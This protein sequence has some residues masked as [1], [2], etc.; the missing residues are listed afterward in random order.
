[1]DM[2]IFTRTKLLIGSAALEKLKNSHVV[3]CGCGG[4]GSYSLEALARAGV[5]QIT[6]IDSDRIDKSN[7]NRQIIATADTIGLFKTQAAQERALSINP[8][9]KF[10]AVN[11]F[12]DSDNTADIISKNADFIIDAV[13]FVPA[14]TALALFSQNTS[15]SLISCLGT[16]NRTDATKFEICDIYKTDTCPLARKMRYE[17][18][19]AGVKK[20]TVLYS[21]AKTV[22]AYSG[23][24]NGDSTVGSISY[25]PSV[26]GLLIAQYVITTLIGDTNI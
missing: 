21:K 25:V 13:D 12:L 24:V 22:K 9:I 14:K 18:R 15:V 7:I 11:A 19:R 16:G 1:M 5:G 10:N 20:L 3:I 6:V 4:V 17:L 26:A 2:E 8:D 23:S